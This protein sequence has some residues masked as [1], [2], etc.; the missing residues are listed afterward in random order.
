MSGL[1]DGVRPPEVTEMPGGCRS[2][3]QVWTR[4]GSQRIGDPA[5]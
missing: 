3:D 1:A 2:N 5:A 4:E